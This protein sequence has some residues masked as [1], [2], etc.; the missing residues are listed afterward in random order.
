MDLVQS[1]NKETLSGLIIFIIGLFTILLSLKMPVGTFRTAGSGLFPLCL[2]VIMTILSSYITIS[3]L[4]KKKEGNKETRDT[5]KCEKASK[6]ILAFLLFTALWVFLFDLIGFAIFSF[7]LV[8][9]LTWLLGAR[10]LLTNIL[11]S[12]SVAVGSYFLFV[13]LL[14][15]PLPKGIL[16]F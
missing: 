15:I 16:G 12:I 6:Q 5:V 3:G 10:K 9:S 7:L 14:K 2:G 13:K 4:S 8:A 11:F 1:R